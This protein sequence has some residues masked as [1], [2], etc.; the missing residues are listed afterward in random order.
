MAIK[1][2]KEVRR[3]KKVH[4]EVRSFYQRYRKYNEEQNRDEEYNN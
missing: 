2:L 1:T 4:R 3:G